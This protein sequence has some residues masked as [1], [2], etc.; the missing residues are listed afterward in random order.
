MSV[1][2]EL[3]QTTRI[4]HEAVEQLVAIDRPDF[5]VHDYAAFLSGML[6]A[7]EPFEH[8]WSALPQ[9]GLWLPDLTTRAKAALLR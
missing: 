3:R 8:G 5:G 1:L 2:D 7:H 6:A 4:D 9:L